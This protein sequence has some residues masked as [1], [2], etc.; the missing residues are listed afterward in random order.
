MPGIDEKEN[1]I[2]KWILDSLG[3]AAMQ[4]RQ[5]EVSEAYHTTF[6]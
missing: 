2:R 1:S 4:N 5:E 6:E 3:F